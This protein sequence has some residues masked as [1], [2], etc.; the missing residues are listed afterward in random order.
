MHLARI[1]FA[2][3]GTALMP[4][5]G[6]SLQRGLDGAALEL[7]PKVNIFTGPNASGKTAVLRLLAAA[8]ETVRSGSGTYRLPEEHPEIAVALETSADWPGTAPG[9]PL[10]TEEATFFHVAAARVPPVPETGHPD[11]LAANIPA[12]DLLRAAQHMDKN[13]FSGKMAEAARDKLARDFIPDNTESLTQKKEEFLMGFVE[14]M[15]AAYGCAYDICSDLLAEPKEDEVYM[16]GIRGV[17]ATSDT[18]VVLPGAAEFGNIREAK[19]I[20]TLSNGTAA[21]LLWLQGLALQ[22]AMDHEWKE[23]WR[24]RTAILTIDEPENSL[25]PQWQKRVLES[26]GGHFPNLQIFAAT[27]SPFI[28]QGT[29]EAR[30][31]RLERTSAGEISISTAAENIAGWSAGRIGA[32]LMNIHEPGPQQAARLR[33]QAAEEAAGDRAGERQE[34][35]RELLRRADAAE[36]DSLEGFTPEGN[37]GR[38]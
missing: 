15:E 20:F 14:A 16:S 2:A 11:M 6:T 12:R 17:Y 10:P 4:D 21:T 29:P 18:R 38:N 36:F 33:R 30:I 25:H 27:H 13:V 9:R 26:L 3:S 35:I 7:H 31:H 19:S 23:G 22:M 24:E 1:A 5:S 8:P 28:V 34:R 32:E 37:S